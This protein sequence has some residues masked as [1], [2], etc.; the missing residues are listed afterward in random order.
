[1]GRI[2]VLESAVADQIAAGEV[3]ERPAS[4][5][6]ELL[7]NALDAGASRVHVELSGGG[8]ERLAVVDDGTGM[9]PDDAV[10]CFSRHATSKLRVADDLRRIGTFGFRGEALAAIASVARVRLM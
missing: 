8:L 3:V 6:K 2:H 7:E 4:V 5:V 1:M 9:E 10:L